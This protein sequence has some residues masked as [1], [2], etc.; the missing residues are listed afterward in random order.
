MYVIDELAKSYNYTVLRLPPYHCELN[1]IEVIRKK[2]RP[3]EKH[4]VQTFGCKK[5]INR[6][7]KPCTHINVENVYQSHEERRD[8]ILRN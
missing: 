6:R 2:S 8:E 7:H 3:N 4:D 5:C 1:P